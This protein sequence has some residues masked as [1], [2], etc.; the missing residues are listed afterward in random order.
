MMELEALAGLDERL[1]RVN[2][3][4]RRGRP[5]DSWTKLE[6]DL[7]RLFAPSRRLAVYGSLAPGESNHGQLDGLSGSWV[8][9]IVRGEL[10][11]GGWGA[12]L[13]YPAMRWDPAGSETV[14]VKLFISDGLP[15]RWPRLDAFEGDGY[16]RMLVPVCEG[17]RWLVAVANLYELK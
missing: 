11:D 15:G 8:D 4:R 13:G 7:E 10:H 9:G 17:S 6:E 3:Y 1:A 2:E 16:Q 12:R 14:D 5:S